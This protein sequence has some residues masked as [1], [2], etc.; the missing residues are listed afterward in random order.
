MKLSLDHLQKINGILVKNTG[1]VNES[2]CFCGSGAKYG[3]CCVKK[4][5]FWLTDEYIKTLINFAKSRNFNVDNIPITFLSKIELAFQNQFNICATPG[6][7]K[8]AINSHVF[9]KALIEKHFN[10][11][12]CQWYAIRDNGKK[13]LIPA[14]INEEIGYKIFCHDCDNN[15]FKQIDDVNHN[16][17]DPI[18]QLTHIFRAVAYQHQFNRV[19][20]ALAHQVVYVT[21]I[22]TEAKNNHTDVQV[23]NR[24]I[25]LTHFQES[26][27]RYQFT[28]GELQKL[29]GILKSKEDLESIPILN[30]IVSSRDPFF[31]QG[32]EDPKRDLSN[33]RIVFSSP[34]AISYVVLAYDSEHI[35]VIISTLNK[36]YSGLLGQ[37]NSANEYRFKKFVSTLIEKKNTLRSVLVGINK[38]SSQRILR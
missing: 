25:D 8:K 20:L 13:E 30:K 14:G 32:I 10:S 38:K 31:A 23:K 27:I 5:N 28:Y 24:D 3:I 19:H 11:K 37:L 2:L 26:Y 34:A 35:Q 17:E 15:I 6:C 33:K 16:I 36:E 22:V 9:G 7:T 29:M 18:N 4:V 1:V 21:P 12:K